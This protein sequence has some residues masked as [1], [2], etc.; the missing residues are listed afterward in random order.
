MPH[1]FGAG[2]IFFGPFPPVCCFP[3]DLARANAPLLLPAIPLVVRIVP[4][5]LMRRSGRPPEKTCGE[6]EYA[7]LCHHAPHRRTFRI[8]TAPA[9][10]K[11]VATAKTTR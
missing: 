9:S 10:R 11:A 2:K 8:N 3:A 5:I 7:R 4:L 1:V 6:P